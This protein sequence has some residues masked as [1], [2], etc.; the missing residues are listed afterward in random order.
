M[1]KSSLQDQ[2]G[3]VKSILL[4]TLLFRV[5]LFGVYIWDESICIIMHMIKFRCSQNYISSFFYI[6]KTSVPYFKQ[7]RKDRDKSRID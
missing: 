7:F 3:S 1:A 6:T 2:R 5:C 4:L